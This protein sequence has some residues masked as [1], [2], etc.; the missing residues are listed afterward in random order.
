MK[1]ITVTFGLVIAAGLFAACG[2][3]ANSGA[4]ANRAGNANGSMSANANTNAN[5]GANS[6]NGSLGN[7][8]AKMATES[9][10]DFM[11]AAAEGGKVEVETS[12]AALTKS[13]NPEVKKFA[14]MMVTDHTKA[15]AELKSLAAKKNVTLPPDAGSRKDDVD[16]LNKTEAADFDAAYVDQMVDDHETTVEMF[17]EQAAN[18]SDPE[19]KAFA[20]KTLPTLKSHLEMIKAIQAKLP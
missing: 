19:V 16:A 11:I 10:Q 13:Q 3:A 17:E 20:A 15:D 18:G 8:I 6:N 9:P 5:S 1:T 2:G 14:Q 7:T 4:N 12:K